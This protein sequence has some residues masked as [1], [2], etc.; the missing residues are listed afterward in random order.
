MSDP[1]AVPIH[2][3]RLTC[4]YGEFTAVDDVTFTVERGEIYALLGTNGAGKTTTLEA[5]EGHRVPSS[6]SVRVLA[7]S[8]TDRARVRPRMGVILQESGFAA[9]LTAEESVD[10]VGAISGRTDDSARLLDRVGLAGKRRTRVAQL[11]GG[12]RRRLDFATAIYGSPELVFLDEPT[13]ALDPAARDRLWDVVTQLRDTGTTI[14]MTTHY[15]EEAERYA[16]RIGLMH[17]GRLQ[18]EG[19]LAELVAAFPAHIEFRAQTG[20]RALPGPFERNDTDRFSAQTRSPQE[21]MLRLLRWAE[22]EGVGLDGLRC[23]PSSLTE[24]FRGLDR[25]PGSV[26]REEARR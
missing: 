3:D 26:T 25:Q 21:D 16:D 24:I 19:T 11:S 9:E 10:L 1:A 13:T 2:V 22:A 5:L 7:A 12:E 18:H 4:R 14:L 20:D 23:T 8:P 17:A 6:G 15:L